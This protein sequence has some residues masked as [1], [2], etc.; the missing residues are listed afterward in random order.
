[1]LQESQGQ[2]DTKG[3]IIFLVT[4]SAE[5][6]DNI[7]KKLNIIQIIPHIALVRFY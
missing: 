2:V 4:H 6:N 1:M 3:N 5:V 7:T